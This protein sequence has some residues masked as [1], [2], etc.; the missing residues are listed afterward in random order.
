[1][2]EIK[3]TERGFGIGEFK[4]TAGHV[5]TV[6][7]SSSA[8]EAKIW[9]GVHDVHAEQG[10]PWKPFPIP[11]DVSVWTRMHLN[12]EQVRALLPILQRF[13]DTGSVR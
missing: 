8:M 7:D 10:P 12:V 4:D 11:D 13:V 1:M 3:S 2:I 5:C 9:L 6:Q